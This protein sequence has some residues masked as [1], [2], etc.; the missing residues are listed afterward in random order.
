M[1]FDYGPNPPPA[2]ADL[3]A[4]ASRGAPKALEAGVVREIIREAQNLA[5]EFSLQIRAING[6]I[7]RRFSE[8]AERTSVTQALEGLVDRLERV[9]M[10]TPAIHSVA[11]T[12]LASRQWSYEGG[13]KEVRFEVG[14]D[15]SQAYR[16]L[17]GISAGDSSPRGGDLPVRVGA[18]WDANRLEQII[19]HSDL[20]SAPKF[21]GGEWS[22]GSPVWDGLQR[23]YQA[24][25]AFGAGI[26]P[27]QAAAR[28]AVSRGFLDMVNRLEYAGMLG[29][30]GV[31]EGAFRLLAE[32]GHWKLPEIA[33]LS[34]PADA[35]SSWTYNSFRGNLNAFATQNGLIRLL[36]H[37]HRW[38]E[39]A[40]FA[41]QIDGT[42]GEHTF[43]GKTR[44][45]ESLI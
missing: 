30:R 21:E 29:F 28:K 43:E 24:A 16:E 31:V 34:W 13:V 40:L 1:H 6:L 17:R 8:G 14:A 35:R 11:V 36:A 12:E 4:R 23:L 42:S 9:G 26:E 3:S 33:P 41:I 45:R 27:E 18:A 10:L 2:A 39:P 25:I 20:R 38:R 15:R 32:E 44:S 37:P 7:A 19:G 5:P 22:R